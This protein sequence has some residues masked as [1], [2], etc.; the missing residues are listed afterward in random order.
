[1][2]GAVKD[3]EVRE[4]DRRASVA[5]NGLD[6]GHGALSLVFVAVALHQPH[7]LTFAQLAPQ[8]LLEE[9]GVARNDV[10]G[11]TKNRPGRAV[12]LLQGNHT[13]LREFLR[14][15]LEVVDGGAAPTVDALVI[16]PHRREAR[17]AP[18]IRMRHQRL[19]QLVL[20]RIGVLILVH[21][22]VMKA[23][24]PLQPHRFVAQQ[25]LQRQTDQVIEVHRLVG[26][27]PLLI[28]L[29]HASGHA[30][31]FVL[32]HGCSP[33]AVQPLVLPQADG[34]LPL[35]R[36]LGVGGGPRIAQEAQHI[37]AVQD[38]EP[39]LQAQGRPV[40][41][42]QAHAQAVEGADHQSRGCP[43]PHQ[44]LGALAHFLCGLVGEGDGRDL[45]GLQ[46]RLQQPCDLVRDHARLARTGA[47]HNKTRSVQV[48]N[49]LQLGRVQTDRGGRG[50]HADGG[51]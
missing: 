26:L 17:R 34:P 39:L 20:H 32:R 22:H 28:E 45:A 10:V 19:H 29:H 25:Q 23:I 27:Q 13:Q 9:L 36:Q 16:V 47:S 8:L 43:R 21:Q 6:K 2:V 3:G 24:L 37:V 42:Q 14:Q 35:P 12:V 15:A 44:G 31:V 30:F 4:L 46:P 49:R 40:F 18:W 11:R 51:G 33:V 5:A 7:W 50:G 38:A 1:M 41:A 48:V